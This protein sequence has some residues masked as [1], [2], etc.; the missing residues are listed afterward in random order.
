MADD[1]QSTAQRLAA[2][3]ANFA[4]EMKAWGIHVGMGKVPHCVTCGQPWPC[5]ESGAKDG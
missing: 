2:G 4:K 3:A 1:P 5:P